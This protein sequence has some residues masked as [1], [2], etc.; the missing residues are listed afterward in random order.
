[1]GFDPKAA[2]M[3]A[4]LLQHQEY[5]AT[6]F[7]G[8]ADTKAL[9]IYLYHFKSVFTVS[10]HSFNSDPARLGCCA[11][12][13]GPGVSLDANKE[14]LRV[15]MAQLVLIVDDE[16]VQRRL[17]EEAVKRFGY[18]VAIAEDGRSALD[19]LSSPKGREVAAIILDLVMPDVDGM[20][21]LKE[22]QANRADLPVIVQTAN[23][24]IE[25]VVKAMRAGAD[26]FVV[27]PFSP[28]RLQ[29]SINNALRV[30]A[31]TGEIKRI[32]KTSDGQLTFG[33]MVASSEAMAQVIRLGERAAQSNIPILIEGESG[34]G[35]E[36][37]ARAIQGTGNRRGKPFV[38]VNCGAIPGNLVE[39]ILFGHEKGA[40]TGAAS[41]HAGKF[42]E[43]HGGTLFLDEVGELPL[44]I[45]V[46]LLRALQDGEIDPVGAKRPH[47]VDVRIISATNRNMIDL[48]TEGKFREDLYYRLN[49]FPVFVPPLRERI[50]DIERLANHFLTRCSAQEGKKI[51]TISHNALNLLNAYSWPGNVRQ[52]ENTMFRAIVLC[53]SDTLDI[54][55]FPQI[56]SLVEGFEPVA[57]PAP[58]VQTL[59]PPLQAMISD[60]YA[61]APRFESGTNGGSSHDISAITDAGQIRRLEDVEADMIKLALNR[62]HGHMSKVARELGIGRSTLYRKV[63]EMGIEA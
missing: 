58:E 39:S 22:L 53:D 30:N 6:R 60:S 43:A 15:C 21:V 2:Y 40:F 62:Y 9:T 49:V 16:A 47:K 27:K 11:K 28:E 19:F 3:G 51:S 46:K 7:S 4:S 35:K 34:V 33:D 24:S 50:G 48:V 55:D 54:C 17:L 29:V 42:L 18:D 25:A 36:L 31:L 44:D 61:A 13:P 20:A 1:M 56:A 32:K 41:K 10:L 12:N 57:P 45:Q 23:G 5:K 52:L 14:A 63:R 8:P 26:D 59:N 37:I 38:T